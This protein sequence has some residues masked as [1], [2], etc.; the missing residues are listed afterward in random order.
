MAFLDETG[1]AELWALVKAEDTKLAQAD[2]HVAA[3][4]YTGTDKYGSSDPCSLTFD[5]APKCL[6]IVSGEFNA[7]GSTSYTAQAILLG[8]SSSYTVTGSVTYGNQANKGQVYVKVSGNTIY[9]YSTNAQYQ[10]NA[11]CKYYYVAIG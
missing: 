11:K 3:G 10:L 8:S 2:V 1:L 9:W 5:F 7:T 4:T 6:L